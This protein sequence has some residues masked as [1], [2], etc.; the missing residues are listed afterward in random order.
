MS[1]T[2]QVPTA[3]RS[4]APD[5]A[6]GGTW[7]VLVAVA[8]VL[9]TFAAS[10]VFFQ[11]FLGI[12]RQ[13]GDIPP[14]N[15]VPDTPA[16]HRYLQWMHWGTIGLVVAGVI[17]LAGL[18]GGIAMARRPDSYKRGVWAIALSAC[19]PVLAIMLLA[20]MGAS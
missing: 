10:M 8:A 5:D 4:T 6:R 18:V 7:A 13:P 19:T 16:T 14:I 2:Q 9:V 20:G 11:G 1:S 3:P 12:A 17:A 15:H